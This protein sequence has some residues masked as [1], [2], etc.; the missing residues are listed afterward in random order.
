MRISDWSSDV[1]S[2]DLIRESCGLLDFKDVA[3]EARRFLSLPRPDP[4]PEP[5]P[6]PSSAPAGSPESARRLFAMSQPIT[7]TVVETYLRHRCITSL[8]A[9]GARSE[10][11]TVELQ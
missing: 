3:E 7:G 2:S 11:H 9:T 6:R 4:D 8:H 5:K 1:C 10:E